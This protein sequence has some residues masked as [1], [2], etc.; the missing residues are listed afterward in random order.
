MTSEPS[1][2][3]KA[4]NCIRSR[5]GKP[6][7]S[8]NAVASVTMPRMPH[9]DTTMPLLNDGMAGTFAPRNR[10]SAKTSHTPMRKTTTQAA[11]ARMTAT[12]TKAAISQYCSRTASSS[13]LQIG[14][15]CIP[16]R[17]KAST[18]RMKTTVS[19]TA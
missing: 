11:R 17:M 1:T 13:R 19:Q 6:S 16:I 5:W 4:M 9:Q 2:T 12:S 7:G 18:F 15:S 14:R 3:A 8:A 10:P